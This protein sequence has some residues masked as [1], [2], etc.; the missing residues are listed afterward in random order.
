M[1]STDYLSTKPASD[2]AAAVGAMRGAPTSRWM[3]YARG[4]A[5]FAVWL[6]LVDKRVARKVGISL[7][8]LG[9]CTLRDWFEDGLSP[10]EAA[11]EALASDDTY[12]FL[13]RA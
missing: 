4:D 8:D 3:V 7:F 9:D 11:G 10:S 13:V 2:V 1:S 5:R 6:A 12:A